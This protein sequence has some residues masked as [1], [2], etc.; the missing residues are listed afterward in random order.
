LEGVVEDPRFY[1]TDEL[2]IRL[3]HWQASQHRRT[4]REMLHGEEYDALLDAK[5][6]AIHSGQSMADLIHITD[7]GNARYKSRVK[8]VLVGGLARELWDWPCPAAPYL[9]ESQ[10]QAGDMS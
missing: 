1:T 2:L 3:V 5:W 6:I 4:S 9:V 10:H 8:R 7:T